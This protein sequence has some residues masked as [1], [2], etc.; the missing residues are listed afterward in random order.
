[1]KFTDEA[2]AA[3]E[4]APARLEEILSLFRRTLTQI[5]IGDV[6][7]RDTRQ[8]A[9]KALDREERIRLE[10]AKVDGR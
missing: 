5:A 8:L 1:M 4:Q 3:A 2:Q 10:T 9:R 7:G 6:T